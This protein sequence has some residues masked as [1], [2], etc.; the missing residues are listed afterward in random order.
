MVNHYFPKHSWLEAIAIPKAWRNGE[1]F[2]AVLPEDTALLLDIIDSQSESLERV[3][4]LPTATRMT[5][6]L[7][8]PSRYRPVVS[9]SHSKHWDATPC[10][11]IAIH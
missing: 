1:F 9:R 4:I 5:S 10:Y 11:E 3:V 2:T 7:P 8:S 6:E